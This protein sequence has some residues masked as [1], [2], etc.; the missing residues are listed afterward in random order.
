MQFLFQLLLF[1][2]LA[3]SIHALPEY[4]KETL[5]EILNLKPL[6]S[7]ILMS[8]LPQQTLA[9]AEKIELRRRGARGKFAYG[10]RGERVVPLRSGVYA[11]LAWGRFLDITKDHPPVDTITIF[12]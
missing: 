11:A 4:R 6:P 3:L 7:V 9:P 12:S 10:Y 8:G 5:E 2:T 1:T